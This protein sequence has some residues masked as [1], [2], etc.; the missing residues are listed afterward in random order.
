MAHGVL[1][2]WRGRL[3]RYSEG[4]DFVRLLEHH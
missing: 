4:Y 3:S 1:Q 2:I